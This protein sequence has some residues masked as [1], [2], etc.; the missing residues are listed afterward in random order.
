M[1]VM[2]M[3][4]DFDDIVEQFFK[5]YQDRGM[6]KWA[7]FYLS[8]HTL[9]IKQDEKKRHIVYQKL[10]EMTLEEISDLLLKAYSLQLPVKVQ[11]KNLDDQLKYSADIAGYVM[12]GLYRRSYCSSEI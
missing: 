4:K 3:S 7:G 6:L 1:A 11:L 9:K 2:R 5:N 8:D 12:D 10:D